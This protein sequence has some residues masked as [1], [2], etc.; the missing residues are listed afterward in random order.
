MKNTNKFIKI[1]KRNYEPNEKERFIEIISGI[2]SLWDRSNNVEQFFEISTY[3][4]YFY[5]IIENLICLHYG[6][7]KGDII[8][9]WVFYRKD[10]DNNT[11]PIHITPK[12]GNTYETIIETPEELWDLL[13]K[14]NLDLNIN[15]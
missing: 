15:D 2:E 9:W 4:D 13:E 14:L 11:I 3:E 12:D 7:D 6:E 5:V 8:L 10:E 1:K